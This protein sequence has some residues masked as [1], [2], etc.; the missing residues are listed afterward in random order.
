MSSCLGAFELRVRYQE[1]DQSGVVYHSNYFNYFEVGRTELLR[2]LGAPYRHLEEQGLRL[3]VVEACARYLLPARY[4][5]LIRVET[6]LSSMAGAR[7]AFLTR[8]LRIEGR[9]PLTLLAT[10]STA[11][12]CLDA[13]SGRPRRLPRAL[14][15]LLES[16]PC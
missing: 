6:R 12:A 9:M 1:T 5:D 11:L 4:D 8:V 7:V 16:P 2:S 13:V 14:R 15:E 3:T 10:G